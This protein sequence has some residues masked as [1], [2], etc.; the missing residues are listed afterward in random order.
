MSPTVFYGLGLR[1]SVD[2]FEKG[3][4]VNLHIYSQKNVNTILSCNSLVLSY[5]PRE[6]FT[7]LESIQGRSLIMIFS[8][9]HHHLPSFSLTRVWKFINNLPL[10]S[11]QKFSN[12]KLRRPWRNRRVAN[13]QRETLSK[14][15]QKIP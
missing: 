3:F 10:L 6:Y 7:K 5:F 14:I 2:G 1:P 9:T 11:Q 15:Q 13:N 4:V 12:S 8:P